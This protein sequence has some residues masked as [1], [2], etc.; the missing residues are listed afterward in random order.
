V[1]LEARRDTVLALHRSPT[2]PSRRVRLKARRDTVLALHRSPTPFT[3]PTPTR[4]LRLEARRDTVLALHRSHA[5]RPPRRR[6]RLD[7]YSVFRPST[8]GPPGGGPIHRPKSPRVAYDLDRWSRYG[9]RSGL[10]HAA[11]PCEPS[12]EGDHRSAHAA[13][14]TL[15]ISH[16]ACFAS[17]VGRDADHPFARGGT[18][19]A[20]RVDAGTGGVPP[21]AHPF[22]ISSVRAQSPVATESERSGATGRRGTR[23]GDRSPDSLR[24]GRGLGEP[25]GNQLRPLRIS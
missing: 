24:Q 14:C 6:R 1:R 16:A 7:G 17:S 3:R 15:A 22:L 19:A 23:L 21:S 9:I 5:V 25:P 12:V 18:P 11:T 20:T 2:P 10:T 13:G 8:G 4:R